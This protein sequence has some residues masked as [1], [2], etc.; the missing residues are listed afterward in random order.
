[1]SGY[2]KANSVAAVALLGFMSVCGT[3]AQA[4]KAANPDPLT[5]EQVNFFASIVNFAR[6][7][8]FNDKTTSEEMILGAVDGALKTLDP[9]SAYIPAAQMKEM[10]EAQSGGFVGI[11]IEIIADQNYI[12]VV[13]PIDDTPAF[14]AGIQAGD[15]ITSVDPDAG[16]DQPAQSTLN[17]TTAQASKLMRGVAGTP[18]TLT[19]VRDGKELPPLTLVRAA[20]QTSPVKAK[21]I[22]SDIGYIRLT[23]FSDQTGAADMEEAI[24]KLG[25]KDSYILDLRNTPGGLVDQ[26]IKVAD[27]FVDSTEVITST[28]GRIPQ[29]APARATPGDIINGKKLIVLTNGG[30][31][32]ASELVSGALQDLGRA[33]IL[34]TQTFGKGSVHTVFDLGRYFPGRE[35][36]F[37]VTTAL[38][39]TPAGRSIHGKGVTPNIRFDDPDAP[40]R[41]TEADLPGAIANP[42]NSAPPI[43][44][45]F[46]C[47]ADPGKKVPKN[48]DPA[49]IDQRTGKP[50][51]QL[52]CAVE[53]LRGKPS[54]T[55]TVVV[56]M[57]PQQPAPPPVPKP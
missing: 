39:F 34:G 5:D 52:I 46:A 18:V 22:G 14:R 19:V 17:F 33:K 23:S 31:A 7:I 36:G 45:E 30:S 3:D 47:A 4:Q 1:M 11:G 53:S 16:G 13:S 6:T 44:S 56:P 10:K 27:M 41:I 21:A 2:F 43:F 55:K 24:K 26:A 29:P 54:L 12:K 32:S 50:D 9:H 25:E 42:D 57:P 40:K 28:R 8:S 35:D 38:Y 49:L 20:I 37:Q 15:Y 48:L 51:Y